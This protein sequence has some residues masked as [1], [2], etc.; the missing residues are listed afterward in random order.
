MKH[1]VKSTMHGYYIVSENGDE[2]GPF[3]THLLAST[4]AEAM[5]RPPAPSTG[6][7]RWDDEPQAEPW[8]EPEHPSL[9]F[10]P[11]TLG[12]VLTIAGI[13]ALCITS[14]VHAKDFAGDAKKHRSSRV[15][16]APAATANHPVSPANSISRS[17]LGGVNTASR[18]V[19]VGT[20]AT[21]A[22]TNRPGINLLSVR[23]TDN[24][25]RIVPSAAIPSPT[26]L[27][28]RPAQFHGR[29]TQGQGRPATSAGRVAPTARSAAQ[30]S[31]FI[32][33]CRQT[34]LDRIEQIE[35]RG[36]QFAIGDRGR[37][38]GAWQFHRAAWT[39]ISESRRKR[40]LPAW[41][42]QHATNRAVARIYAAEHIE[43]LTTYLAKR[44]GRP[45]TRGETYA[46]YNCGASRFARLGFSLAACPPSTRRAI[47]KLYA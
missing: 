33:P 21:T 3:S 34:L 32:T 7:A 5:S 9:A 2:I 22:P 20:L 26:S 18:R 46:A 12:W 15:C 10:W 24:T 45:P 1:R 30:D 39:Q 44:L 23:P 25:G 14:C 38:R 4:Q 29:Q 8:P 31:G 36:N 40:G 47:R 27:A 6:K 17:E 28:I 19:C 43:Q 16:A 41:S 11:L 37:A 13:I 35:S 42:Y